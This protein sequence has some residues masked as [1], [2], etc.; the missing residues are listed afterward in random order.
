MLV[1]SVARAT[2]GSTGDRVEATRQRE[3]AGGDMGLVDRIERKLESTV[4]D[5]IARVFGGSIGPQEVETAWC[6]EAESRARTVAG[7]Q[8]LAPNDYVITL[9]GTDYQ[10]VSADTDLTSTAFAKHLGGFIRDQGWQ[11]YGD[12]VVRFEQSPNL[13]TGQSR[14]HGAVNPDSTAG[15][16]AR[17]QGDHAFTAESGE[18]PMTDNPNYRGGQGQG[19]PG[20]EYYDDR[21]GHPQDDPRGGQYPPEQGGYPPQEQGGG[22]PPRQRGGYGGG[23]GG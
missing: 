21:Y 17:A 18:P 13:H 3:K 2:R 1:S 19:R 11:T 8:V 4:G 14:A 7:G 12:V 6:R 9:S 22:Y 10:K 15:E 20:D 5:A 16:S 23:R